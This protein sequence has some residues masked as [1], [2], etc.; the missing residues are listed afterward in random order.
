MDLF[1]ANSLKIDA[2]VH[3]FFESLGN[4]NEKDEIM[5]QFVSQMLDF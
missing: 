2:N 5:Q 3:L 4:P 1:E